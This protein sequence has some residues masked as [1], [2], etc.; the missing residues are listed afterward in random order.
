MAAPRAQ[1]APPLTFTCV[2]PLDHADEIK[3]LFLAHERPEFPAFFDRAYPEAVAAGACRWGG[4]GGRGRICSHVVQF[5]RRF[6]FAGPAGRGALFGK[7]LGAT[8]YPAL[9]PPLSPP[10]P[11]RAGLRESGT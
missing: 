2:N 9:W 5:P 10:P 11:A 3:Q 4:R 8:A 7:L 6:V 1:V